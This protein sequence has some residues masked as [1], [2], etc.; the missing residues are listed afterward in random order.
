M[1]PDSEAESDAEGPVLPRLSLAALSGETADAAGEFLASTLDGL[2]T[3]TLRVHHPTGMLAP[4]L[5]PLLP[6]CRCISS[7]QPPHQ[8]SSSSSAD[9]RPDVVDA[10][11]PLD[12]MLRIPVRSVDTMDLIRVPGGECPS[13]LVS[14]LTPRS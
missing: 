6:P 4:A 11:T 9:A 7:E 2:D 14:S 12:S 13:P 5:M 10:E 3:P 8:G 1:A